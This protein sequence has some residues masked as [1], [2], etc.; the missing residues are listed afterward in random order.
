SAPTVVGGTADRFVKAGSCHDDHL[1]V[2][3]T[4]HVLSD[5]LIGACRPGKNV[6]GFTFGRGGVSVRPAV[7]DD[8]PKARL[9]V[10]EPLDYVCLVKIVGDNADR[11]G[12]VGDG[13]IEQP[14]NLLP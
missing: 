12:L 2:L 6:S 5:H 1:V 14:E 13:G 10:F 4:A 11:A 9:K 7:V 8:N 3:E